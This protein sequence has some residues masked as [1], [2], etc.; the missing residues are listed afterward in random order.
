[1]D[2]LIVKKRWLDL[3]ISGKKTIEIRGSN[4]KKTGEKIY[5]LESITHK[6]RA[7][8]VIE[9]TYPISCSDWSE[10]RNKHCVDVSYADLKR[11]YKTPYAWVFSRI[12]PITDTWYY[13]HP[14]GAVI[15]VKDV[16]LC[17]KIHV[18]KHVEKQEK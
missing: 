6:V 18:H 7:E 4:T 12:E 15:W 3:I 11:R 10:E 2:G 17:D 8:C 13:D 1:M 5:L 16:R 9:T 14:T